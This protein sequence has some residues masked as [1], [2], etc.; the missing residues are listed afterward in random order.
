[1]IVKA[2]EVIC[3][4]SG[5]VEGYARAGPLVA[6]QDFDLDSFVAETMKPLTEKWE[7]SSLF[8]DIPGCFSR[9]DSSPSGPVGRSIWGIWARS[10][11]GKR[12]K[13]SEVWVDSGGSPPVASRRSRH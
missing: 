13:I 3:T 7:V 1:M 8:G 9:A 10:T 11:S 2:G 12:R 6:T 4:A 5:I